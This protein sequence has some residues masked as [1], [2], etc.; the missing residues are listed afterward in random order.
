MSSELAERERKSGERS[1]GAGSDRDDCSRACRVSV[2]AYN[3]SG[4]EDEG[5]ALAAQ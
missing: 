4:G 5:P 1:R 3:V 2:R